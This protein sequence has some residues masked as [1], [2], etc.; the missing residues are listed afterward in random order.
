MTFPY[1]VTPLSIAQL[2]ALRGELGRAKAFGPFADDE[3]FDAVVTVVRAAIA[4]P[5]VT[6]EQ[7]AAAVTLGNFPEVWSGLLGVPVKRVAPGEAGA[8]QG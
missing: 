8:G 3:V 5:A 4:D 2:K 6:A 7:V 1:P